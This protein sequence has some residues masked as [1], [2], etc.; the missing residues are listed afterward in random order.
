MRVGA[1]TRAPAHCRSRKIWNDQVAIHEAYSA[2]D[3]AAY[4][5]ALAALV[6]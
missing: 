6:P 3:E 2:V 5:D 1:S 4:E